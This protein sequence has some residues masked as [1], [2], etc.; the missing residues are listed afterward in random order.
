MFTYPQSFMK[1]PPPS[2]GGSWEYASIAIAEASGDPWVD[3]D[4]VQITGGALFVYKSA[5]AV[6]SYSGLIHKEPYGSTLGTLASVANIGV[7]AQGSDPDTWGWYDAS[8]GTKGVD[9]DFDAA[10]SR[11]RARAI[12]NSDI[13]SVHGVS[14][15]SS[16]TETFA[17]FDALKM[18]F[19][20]T[21]STDSNRAQHS[22]WSYN[23]TSYAGIYLRNRWALS[24][25]TLNWTLL[26]GG[27]EA[28]TGKSFGTERR[29]WM[30]VKNGRWAL[31]F[32][33]GATP[34][35]SGTVP[36]TASSSYIARFRSQNGPKTTNNYNSVIQIAA[37]RMATL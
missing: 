1:S 27:G 5:L 35:M 2:G 29:V 11:S 21:D 14:L 36:A 20:G 25:A 22:V 28:S 9:Y 19:T 31:W 37:G 8:S 17:I 7:T 18:S 10:S 30:Y 34:T 15:T 16:D 24:G 3:G 4:D 32:D 26:H 33:A 12:G 13:A 23:G 6:S